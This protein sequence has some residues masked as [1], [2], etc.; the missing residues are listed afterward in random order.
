MAF[1]YTFDLTRTEIE[2]LL[3]SASNFS[4]LFGGLKKKILA[5]AS[6]RI[7]ERNEGKVTVELSETGIRLTDDRGVRDMVWAKVHYVV[8]RPGLWTTQ[9]VEHGAAILPASAVPEEDRAALAEQLRAWV[10]GKYTV[11][12]GGVG[13]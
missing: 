2:E 9:D 1:A 11:R 10:G 4:G 13:R 5:S 8:E 6:A 3:A 12:D 7:A